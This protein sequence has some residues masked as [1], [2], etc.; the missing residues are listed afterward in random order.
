MMV[1]YHDLYVNL[2][3]FKIPLFFMVG[4]G[5]WEWLWKFGMGVEVK[6]VCGGWEWL[7]KFGMCVEVKNGCGGWEWLWNG[8]GG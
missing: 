8:C 6:N 4:C 3:G 2:S 5:G 7:W 1:D